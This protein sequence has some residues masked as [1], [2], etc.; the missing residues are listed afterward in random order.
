LYLLKIRKRGEMESED[1]RHGSS[2][3]R[4]RNTARGLRGSKKKEPSNH[5]GPE[6]KKKFIYSK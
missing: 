6:R 2:S 3:I 4:A 1:R 5:E